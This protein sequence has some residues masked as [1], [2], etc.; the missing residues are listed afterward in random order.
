VVVE[1][2]GTSS[3]CPKCSSKLK[4]NGYRRLKCPVCGLENDRDIIAVL[5]IERRAL[6]KMGGSLTTPTAPQMT[7]VN[8]NRCGEPVT[9]PKGTLA[10]LGRGG[11]QNGLISTS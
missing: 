7:D 1:P 5:N 2:K 6:L 11:G 9:R 8:P 10:P 3:T 4:E